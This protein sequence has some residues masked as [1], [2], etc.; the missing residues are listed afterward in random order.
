MAPT[1]KVL[2]ANSPLH[3]AHQ[4]H[5]VY[6]SS[7]SQK[8]FGPTFAAWVARRNIVTVLMVGVAVKVFIGSLLLQQHA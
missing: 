7:N 4:V 8:T 5:H 1:E 6:P 2:T 3:R